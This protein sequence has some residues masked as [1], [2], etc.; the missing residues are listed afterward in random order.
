MKT[1]T[2]KRMLLWSLLAVMLMSILTVWVWNRLPADAAIPVHWNWRGEIDRYGGKWEGLALMPLLTLGMSLLLYFLPYF[3]PRGQNVVRSARAY[4]AIWLILLLFFLGFHTIVVLNLLGYGVS[5]TSVLLPGLGLLFMGLGNYMGKLRRNY[6]M[7]IRT[8]WTLDSDLVWNKTHRLGGKLMFI[9]GALTVLAALFLPHNLAIFVLLF[10]L[11]GSV[12]WS[13]AYS[14]WI[15][16]TEV[17]PQQ[18][19][20]G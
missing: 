9:A 10:T 8:P 2:S 5:I 19:V 14:Y 7:G 1:Q 17:R 15:W 12:I 4:H 13:V 11:L 16:R 20:Q 6:F 3:D 18:A